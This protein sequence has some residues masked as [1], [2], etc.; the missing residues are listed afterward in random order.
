MQGG[1]RIVLDLARP[2]RIDQAVVLKPAMTSPLAWC[3]NS[4][5][6]TVTP[7]CVASRPR[8]ARPSRRWRPLPRS[9]EPDSKAA[10]D[11]RRLVV[12]DPGHGG[13]D[14]GTRLA[15]SDSP[16]KNL[17][18]DFGLLLRDKI[19]KSANTAPP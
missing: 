5:P 14:I 4:P 1:S 16:E 7:S 3:W 9:R 19:E 6:S 10:N 13:L 11:P 18:L 12:I 15:P 2:A 8:A 17:V